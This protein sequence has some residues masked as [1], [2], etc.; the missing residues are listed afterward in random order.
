[1]YHKFILQQTD[2]IDYKLTT[3]TYLPSTL[4]WSLGKK[5]AEMQFQN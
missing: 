4:T 3:S 1:M 5:E 2:R